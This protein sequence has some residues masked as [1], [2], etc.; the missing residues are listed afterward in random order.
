MSEAYSLRGGTDKAQD[1]VVVKGVSE[2]SC[3]LTNRV[4]LRTTSALPNQSNFSP[5]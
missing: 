3:L 1:V 4:V 5:V 2:A